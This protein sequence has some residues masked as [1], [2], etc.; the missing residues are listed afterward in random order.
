MGRSGCDPLVAR[1][2]LL[3]TRLG[4]SL[5]FGK[6]VC[7]GG[8]GGVIKKSGYQP[9][10]YRE[11]DQACYVL[12]MQLAEEVLAVGLYRVGTYV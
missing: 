3:E 2:L 11:A 4:Y 12:C 7:G 6:L 9:G 1:V 8:C 10:L 5:V